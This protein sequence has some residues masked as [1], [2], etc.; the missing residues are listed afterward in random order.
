VR[1][2]VIIA[3]FWLAVPLCAAAAAGAVEQAAARF[4]RLSAK[5]PAPLGRQ[6]RALAAKALQT[7]HP[8]LARKL[9]DPAAN[10]L[11]AAPRVDPASSAA[12]LA[13]VLR[14]SQLSRLPTD[15][16]R[17]RLLIQL[18]SE[19]RAL[20]AGPNKFSL[21]WELH[22]A[23]TEG[24]PGQEAL[25]AV[26]DTFADAIPGAPPDAGAYLELA[27]LIRYQH[28]RPSMAD[29]ALDTALALLE[30]R[31]QLHQEAG[32]SLTAIDGR[33]YSLPALRSQV[34]L[35]NF[36]ATTCFSCRIEMPDLEKL[37]REFRGKGLV[38]LAVTDE[39]REAVGKFLATGNYTFP[40]LLDPGR[41]VNT[42]FDID[43]VPQTFVF[44]REGNLVAQ[45]FDMRTES[46]FRAML[47]AAGLE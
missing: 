31:E 47:K 39:T 46:Q 43:G 45:A 36:W 35:L 32:F 28:V 19:V 4:D 14:L 6:F 1:S 34:V 11:P 27:S 23:V 7:R 26:A 42:D 37:Y 44:D 30:L 3:S 9:A 20:P 2:P 12:G 13:I 17:A 21:A 10:P 24:D 40:I 18:A 16:G 8:D 33:R 38:V 5:V 15:A 41:K 25:T 29:S 22:A